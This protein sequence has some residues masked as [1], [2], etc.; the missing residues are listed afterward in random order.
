LP[1]EEPAV[2]LLPA[3][4][5][6]RATYIRSSLDKVYAGKRAGKSKE[7]IQEDVARFAAD[8]PFLFKKVL[9]T[10]DPNDPALRTML[11]ML[12]RMG[13]GD[14]SQDQASAIVGQRLYD[15]YVKPKLGGT[16]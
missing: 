5:K 1:P 14:L 11:S 2:P 9:E 4:A 3:V 12:E 13:T 6:A 16:P 7:E 10:E 15:R 8:Y